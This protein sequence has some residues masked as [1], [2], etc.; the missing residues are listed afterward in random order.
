MDPVTVDLDRS[1]PIRYGLSD[2]RA[3]CAGLTRLQPGERPER[4]TEQM[5]FAMLTNMDNEAFLQ[6]LF[7]GLRGAGDR[8]VTMTDVEDWYIEARRSDRLAGVVQ[9]MIDA[10]EQGGFLRRR[11]SGNGAT[12]TGTSPED[13]ASSTSTPG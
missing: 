9:N 3:V 6:F 10:L 2:M 13:G 11:P 5:A 7:H 12:G 8:K 1:R 4:V